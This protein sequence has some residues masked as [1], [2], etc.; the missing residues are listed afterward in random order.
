MVIRLVVK[1][2]LDDMSSTVL[3]PVGEEKAERIAL[4]TGIVQLVSAALERDDIQEIPSDQP[5]FMKSDRGV[6]SY[7]QV[8]GT[9][10]ICE[11]DNENEAGECVRSV[12]K[13][14]DASTE[15][16]TTRIEKV[17]SKRG[18]EISDLWG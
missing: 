13:E 6:I 10:F 5:H 1:V 15:E 9:L 17:A 18:R 3:Y 14:P 12:A 2:A 8:G 16:L 7:S 11:A 4:L